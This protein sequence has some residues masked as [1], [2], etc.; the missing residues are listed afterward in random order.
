[1]QGL[2]LAG[3]LGT[4][5]QSVA[6]DLPK[7]LLAVHGRPFADYQLSW[8][9]D[10][11]IDRV[12]YAIGHQ[13][14][15]IRDFAGDGGKW[16]LSIAYADEGGA[17]LG[18]G[19][20]VRHA[21]DE[22]LLDDGFFVMYGDSYLRLDLAA[23]W[24]AAD[25]GR[26]PLMTVFHNDG[27]WDASNT[28]VTEGFVTHYEKGRADAA[29]IGLDHIDYGLSVLTAQAVQDVIKPGKTADLGRV[30]EGLIGAGRLRAFTATERFY[31]I[32]S[33]D[34]LADF[35]AFVLGTGLAP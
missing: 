33:P 31:E 9:R 18:T 28:A 21:L 32:G 22:G 19:G 34:G 25:G 4:R 29:A 23:V 27:R 13:G 5:M 7:T 30:F 15:A 6:P 11:G 20:A 17:R 16:G 12:V 1:M 26:A 8:L 10:Q 35:E 2:I 3:G 14:G 24:A